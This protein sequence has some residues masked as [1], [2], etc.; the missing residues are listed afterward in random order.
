MT[1]S[2]VI[3]AGALVVLPALA[4]GQEQGG[5][6]VTRGQDTVALERFTREDVEIKGSLIR[7]AGA[8]ARE[9]VRYRAVLVDDQSTPLIDISVWRADDPEESPARQSARVIFK[10]D[11]VAIDDAGRQHGVYTRV[12]PSVPFFN[13]GGGHT[14]TG[15]VLRLGGDSAAVHIG[16]VEF[17][18]WVDTA[19][20]ILGGTV[21][22]QS[23][24]ITRATGR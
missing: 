16:T 9:R 24:V 2:F 21:P 11:S 10:D 8:S 4:H 20:R 17:R 14:V 6:A 5:F 15:T 3:V 18:V 7:T 23:L 1:R 13:L 19:C 22:S 12:F